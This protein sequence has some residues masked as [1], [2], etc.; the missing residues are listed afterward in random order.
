MARPPLLLH[1]GTHKTGTTAI[2]SVLDKDRERLQEA[3]IHYPSLYPEFAAQPDKAAP[4]HHQVSHSVA[5]STLR[6]RIPMMKFRRRIQKAARSS[7]LTLLSAEPV[8]RHVAR[9][10]YIPADPQWL[11]EHAKYLARLKSY[12]KRFD[13]TILLYLREPFTC[14]ESFFKESVT[15][16]T[17][18]PHQSF[19]D[20]VASRLPHFD[21]ARRIEIFEQVFGKV[22]T[23]QYEAA[24]REGLIEAFYK[25]LGLPAPQ[26]EREQVRPS[27]SAQ[28]A[29]WLQ[30]RSAD[31]DRGDHAARVLY[32]VRDPDSLFGGG[33][34]ASLW[35]D[36]AARH[37]FSL[38]LDKTLALPI[39]EGLSPPVAPPAFWSENETRTA[40]EAFADW[41]S[42]NA[43]LLTRRASLG[44]KHYQ[45]D[46]RS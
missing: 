14:A 20:F 9:Q 2:Q 38:S 45:P 28:G 16:Y 33:A 26:V 3:G 6:G 31:G 23:R 27:V 22:E 15:L 18:Q 42:E 39:L 4:A 30:A 40:N 34:R 11:I 1:A 21:Y 29:L 32:A 7:T 13:I 36:E 41:R 10:G 8:Y 19:D 17:G 44:L 46:P 5:R 12:L 35:S 24:C 43:K 25:D 37:A